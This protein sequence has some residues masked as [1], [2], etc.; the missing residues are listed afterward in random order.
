MMP[1]TF[2]ALIGA[3][4]GI[5]TVG[6]GAFGAHALKSVLDSYG[7]SIWEKAVFYQAIH[8]LLLLILPG[9]SSYLTPKELNVSGYLIIIGIFLFSGSLYIL[10]ISGKKYFGA[11]TPIGGVAFIVGWSWLAYAL[12]KATFRS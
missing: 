6:L 12:F 10:A 3:I 4:F 9:L 1:A 5:L 11:I 7:Q 2:F 8:S